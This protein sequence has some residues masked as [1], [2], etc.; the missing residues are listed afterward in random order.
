[1]STSGERLLDADGVRVLTTELLPRA[2][3]VTPNI[4]EAEALSGCRIRSPEDIRR[5]AVRIREMGAGA[6]IVTGGHALA[7]QEP[8]ADAIDL[9][10]DGH[11]FTEC[12]TRRIEAGPLH[13]TGCAFSSAL[14]ACLALGFPLEE[15]ARRAQAYVAGA[16]AH[17]HAIGHG[18]RVLDHASGRILRP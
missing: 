6:V 3:V 5:A 8:T 10:Y 12:R 15:S 13:G 7:G 14:A 18:A 4:P 2:F 1:V 17:A 11:T 16:I 9:L